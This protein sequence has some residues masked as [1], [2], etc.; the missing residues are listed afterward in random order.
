[1]GSSKKPKQQVADYFLSLHYG[2]CYGPVDEI[3]RF[4]IGEKVVWEGSSTGAAPIVI[5]K[6]NM[7]GG[8]KEQGGYEGNI[9]VLQGSVSQVLPTWMAQKMADPSRVPGFR[10]VLTTFFAGRGNSGG[11][12]WGSNN[13]YVRDVWMKVFRRPK[14]FY[15]ERST[16]PRA[17]GSSDL[18]ANPAH[19]IWECVTNT[20]WGCGVPPSMI[21]FISMKAAADALYDEGFGLSMIWT[22]QQAIE[23]FVN[24]VLRHI[25][26]TFEIHPRTGLY[27]LTLIRGD[28]TTDGLLELTPDNFKL[29]RF[30]R[31][32]WD[33]TT[34]EVN[35]TWTNP[36]NEEQETV[37]YHDL[38]NISQQGGNIVSET[39]DFTG[40]RS[41]SLAMRV[42][43]REAMKKG[44]PLAAVEGVASREAWQVVSGD[45]VLL[46]W[47]KR[48]IYRLPVR[49]TNVD[50]GAP[51]SPGIIITG[52]EDQFSMPDSPYAVP[53]TSEWVDPSVPPFPLTRVQPVSVPHFM[54]A[55]DVGAEAAAAVEY[56]DTYMAVMASSA[57]N[58]AYS[59]RLSTA[60]VDFTGASAWI[61]VG[62]KSMTPFSTLPQAMVKEATSVIGAFG[63]IESPGTIQP[64]TLLWVGTTGTVHEIMMVTSVSGDGNLTLQR[65]CL[66]TVARQWPAGAPVWFYDPQLAIEDDTVRVDAQSVSYRLQTVTSL[67]VLDIDAAPTVAATAEARS[68]RPYRPA[69]VRMVG[70]LWPGVVAGYAPATQV[71]WSN[72]NRLLEVDQV[73]PWSYGNI[74]PEPGATVTL[75]VLNTNGSVLATQAGLT[76]VSANIDLSGVTGATATLRAWAVRDGVTSYQVEEHTFEVAG[77]GMNYGNYY[78]GV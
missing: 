63:A 19:I 68:W 76:G 36:A 17:G 26:G 7:L 3:K 52:A 55:Q 49:V 6:R 72:R 35:V 51:G 64:G 16:I 60:G 22:G 56:P 11:F 13:P 14:G 46:T 23:D 40:I 45:V 54:L 75:Q 59:F 2:W 44:A 53:P 34:N 33:E 1:M 77:Y 57:V 73:Y 29:T 70:E 38:G 18:D 67:G 27:T 50:R 9:H 4:R 25:D 42:A 66:D 31:R 65:A 30:S 12:Y 32:S 21:D 5:N 43:Q 15:P 28:Y 61:D 47:P 10:G 71:T 58:D 24:T 39:L 74:S 20:D 41:P 62:T 37:T 8:P 78:G 69:N 48:G